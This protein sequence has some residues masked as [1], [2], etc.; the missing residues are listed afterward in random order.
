[1]LTKLCLLLGCF[2]SV[3]IRRIFTVLFVILT[4]CNISFA[5]N[6]SVNLSIQFLSN[7]Q[8]AN[9]NFKQDPFGE[10]AK[11]VTEVLEPYF[12]GF[13]KEQEI[14]IL[15]TFHV[16]KKPTFHIHARPAMF[17]NDMEALKKKL[18]KLKGVKA[19]HVRF[20]LAYIIQL[21][22]GSPDPQA[23]F[24]PLFKVPVKRAFE[25][26]E[27]A[28][29][30][31]M[32]ERIQKWANS[33]VLPILAAIE[34]AS[35]AKMEGVRAVGAMVANTDISESTDVVALTEGNP[36]Y[37]RGVLEM[38]PGNQLVTASKVFL[39]VAKGELDYA[40]KYLEV[41]NYFADPK[42]VAG[43]YF[44][45]LQ[46]R[47]EVFQAE[48]TARINGGIMMHDANHYK[49]AI[50]TY[51]RILDDYPHSAWAMF[52]LYYSRNTLKMY[53]KQADADDRSDW[54]ASK[55]AIF[56]AN[57]LYNMDVRAL[58]AREGYMMQRRAHISELFKS[59]SSFSKDFIELADIS[60]DLEVYGFAA[61]VY[62][63]VMS[64]IPRKEYPD[65]EL[66]PYFLYCLDKLGEKDLKNNFEGD[67]EGDFKRIAEERE[68]LMKE[69]PTYQA[70]QK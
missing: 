47:L 61:H 39:H 62:W 41:L 9:V 27:A 15:E 70:F 57:P 63:L 1:M 53:R 67:L 23:P 7:E 29:L 18:T 12:S 30:K 4:L 8:V 21:N 13:E 16:D 40:G 22:G 50:A 44:R 32:K 56:K 60:L 17:V 11:R 5:Q 6:E 20:H 38:A 46:W 26:L 14:V 66:M 37:W 34:K 35:E 43:Y 33:E 42:T 65:R 54:D 24:V 49:E 51:K 2:L 36:D 69:S 52:E 28:P 31:G 55:G 3:L 64:S 25:R 59:E 19:L 68:Q 58:T 48:L 45:E 10:H